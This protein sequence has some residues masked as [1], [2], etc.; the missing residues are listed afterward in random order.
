[1]EP[2]RANDRAPFITHGVPTHEDS[3]ARPGPREIPLSV[4]RDGVHAALLGID[5]S[6]PAL[7]E[8]A[9]A[10][11]ENPVALLEARHP[12][13]RPVRQGNSW[14][15]LL[16]LSRVRDGGRAQEAGRAMI[17][18]SEF[19]DAMF[20][21]LPPG[22]AAMTAEFPGDPAAARRGAWFARPWMPGDATRGAPS[23]NAYVAVSSFRADPATG[24]F[25]RRKAQ[26][27]RLHALM[28]DD[29]GTKVSLA[30][31]RRLAPSALTET[32][33]GNYQAWLFLRSCEITDSRER[34][35]RLVL[36]MID[37]G[38]QAPTDPGM[39]GVT[40]FGRLPIG[41]NGKAKYRSAS[42]VPFRVRLESW[43]PETRY[44]VAEVA[45]A[46]GLN[47]DAPGPQ[48]AHAPAVTPVRS[49][50]QRIDGFMELLRAVESAGLY[51][52]SLGEGR[53]AVTCP[54]VSS[55][56]GKDGTGSALFE[57]STGNNWLGGFRCHHGHCAD[58]H[59]GHVYAWARGE[60]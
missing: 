30:R 14:A 13:L 39:A 12:F 29:A 4:L 52:G 9:G 21:D 11:G 5:R 2:G 47:L 31:A 18:N 24:E 6:L 36:S 49:A 33:P 53:H 34:A 44:T 17:T 28:I 48:E 46:Y 58:R 26:F 41:T 59:I 27:A 51:Q 20:R 55:H 32:S 42:G 23:W 50:H 38:L 8:T 43:S 37:H 16:A 60:A 54:W 40:R 19:L 10:R 35:E 25:R 45:E 56:T 22:A 3:N 7:L 57:P 1:M 15:S